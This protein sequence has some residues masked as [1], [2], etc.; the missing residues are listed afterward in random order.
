MIH[1][2]PQTDHSS[3]RHS[4][5]TQS[6]SRAQTA[7]GRPFADQANAQCS[8]PSHHTKFNSQL[9][10]CDQNSR[11]LPER[12]RLSVPRVRVQAVFSLYSKPGA[13]AML[14]A[15]AVSAQAA[16]EHTA[17]LAASPSAPRR[18]AASSRPCPRAPRRPRLTLARAAGPLDGAAATQLR[19]AGP[20]TPA[21]SYAEIDAQPLNRVVMALFR[22]KMVESIG[23][24]SQL[25]G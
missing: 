25:Q 3:G 23:S 7:G 19:Q 9:M 1:S 8:S 11:S 6:V 15:P 4:K 12:S 13:T 21:P 5:V 16:N 10:N 18:G 2:L 14:G 17:R 20:G 24:D 22:R